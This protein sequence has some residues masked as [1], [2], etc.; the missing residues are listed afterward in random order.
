VANTMNGLWVL[1]KAKARRLHMTAGTLQLVLSRS[2]ETLPRP[3]KITR[4][5]TTARYE[6]RGVV[7]RMYYAV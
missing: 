1:F 3:T 6:S 7:F 4:A 2:M 5:T